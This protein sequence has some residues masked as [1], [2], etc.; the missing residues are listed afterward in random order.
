MHLF[1]P[2]FLNI[3]FP[4]NCTPVQFTA[5]HTYLSLAGGSL[6]FCVIS[7]K[8]LWM[9]SRIEKW[10]IFL[11]IIFLSP[12]GTVNFPPVTRCM[13]PVCRIH[14]GRPPTLA[15]MSWMYDVKS[16]PKINTRTRKNSEMYFC[17]TSPFTKMIFF[18]ICTQI[19]TIWLLV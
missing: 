10:F 2:L 6:G 1:H 11:K 7:C 4:I 15:V 3:Y 16:S 19:F 17:E 13:L 8:A 18:L 5:P 14:R 12:W 9:P